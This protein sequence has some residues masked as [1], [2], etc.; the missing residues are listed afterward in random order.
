MGPLDLDGRVGTW[1]KAHMG[2]RAPPLC[3]RLTG[4][5]RVPAGT[6]QGAPGGEAFVTPRA[7]WEAK[8]GG[9]R[10][11]ALGRMAAFGLLSWRI[12][13]CHYIITQRKQ[14]S[15]GGV[16]REHSVWYSWAPRGR[17]LL[18]PPGR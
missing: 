11:R 5:W 8:S 1:P 9:H 15:W 4:D 12:R 6:C 14:E 16:E 3:G 13:G 7:S 17:P 18:Q 10:D 2:Q